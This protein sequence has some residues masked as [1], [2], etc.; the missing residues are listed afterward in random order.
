MLA[1]QVELF[2]G[3]FMDLKGPVSESWLCVDCGF[4]TAPGFLNRAELEKAFEADAQGQGVTQRT[5]QRLCV[6]SLERIELLLMRR[7]RRRRSVTMGVLGGSARGIASDV[8][9]NVPT[10]PGPLVGASL[11][12]APTAKLAPSITPSGQEDKRP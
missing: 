12:E 3:G 2:V 8:H 9:L 4:D 10:Q 6:S 1:R 5:S 11:F 7:A